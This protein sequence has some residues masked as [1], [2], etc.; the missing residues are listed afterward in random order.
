M[1]YIYKAIGKDAKGNLK[2]IKF[3]AIRGKTYFYIFV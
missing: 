1:T 3:K 2:N